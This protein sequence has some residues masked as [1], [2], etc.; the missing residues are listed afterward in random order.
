MNKNKI[1]EAITLLLKEGLELDLNEQ[2]LRETPKRAAKGFIEIF[3][4]YDQDPKDYFTTFKEDGYNQMIVVG[5]IKEY[6]M[7]SHHILPF[8]MDIYIG[9]IPNGK[10]I[11]LSKF[12]RISRAISH[13]LQVQERITEE[14]AD[15]IQEELNPLGLIVFIEN[16]KHNCMI[17][18]GVK[19]EGVG[20]STSTIRG[21]LQK[22]EARE[23]FF[24]IIRR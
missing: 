15:I 7:C 18:R 20:V 5:P 12:V 24:N 14:I 4:G 16:S 3:E 6:S 21:V 10:I 11:G 19:C 22:Q 2:H 23:E 9:Y 13:K 8:T 1:E 17:M